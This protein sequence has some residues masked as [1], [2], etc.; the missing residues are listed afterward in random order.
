MKLISIGNATVSLPEHWGE[1]KLL[2]FFELRNYDGSH[3]SCLSIISETPISLWE[4]CQNI[5][6][7]HYILPIVSF[8]NEKFDADKFILPTYLIIEG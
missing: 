6:I 4:C 5:D 7:D 8:L 1:I 3:L 2:H